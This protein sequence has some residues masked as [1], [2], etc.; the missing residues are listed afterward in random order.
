ML[1]RYGIEFKNLDLF[2]RRTLV[3]RGRVKMTCSRRRLKLYFFSH[4]SVSLYFPAWKLPYGWLNAVPARTHFSQHCVNAIL[5]YGAQGS[6]RQT[7]TDPA[8]LALNPEAAVLQIGQEAALGLVVSMGNMVTGNRFLSGD[9]TYS[10]HGNALQ[11][12]KQVL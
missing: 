6:I 9:F 10:C 1:A 5:V 12:P 8:L 2:R 7:Q 11:N 4:I 3:L